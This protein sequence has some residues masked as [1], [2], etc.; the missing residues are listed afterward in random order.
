MCVV[1][2]VCVLCCQVMYLQ[3]QVE[4]SKTG[5]LAPLTRYMMTTTHGSTIC[6]WHLHRDQKGTSM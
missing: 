2:D 6:V 3:L 4:E 5:L 1:V